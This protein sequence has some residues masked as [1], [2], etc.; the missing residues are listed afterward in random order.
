MPKSSVRPKPEAPGGQT[1]RPRLALPWLVPLAVTE[2]VFVGVYWFFANTRGCGSD[3]F[4]P[5]GYAHGGQ[6]K[7]VATGVVLAASVWVGAGVALYKFP[8]WRR[9][10]FGLG[11]AFYAVGLGLLWAITPL[12]WGAGVCPGVAVSHVSGQVGRLL[13]GHTDTIESVAFSPNRRL[14]ASSS[15]D[16]TIRLWDV[17]SQRELGRPLW[18][19]R[20][21][22]HTIAFSPDG[23]EL[24]SGACDGTVRLWDARTHRQLGPALL[25]G[26]DRACVNGVAFSPDGRLLVSGSDFGDGRVRLW[27]VRR[28]TQLGSALGHPGNGFND[29]AFS[30]DG[31]TVVA[32]VD[33]RGFG[34]VVLWDVRSKRQLGQPGRVGLPVQT[35]AFSPSGRLIAS[36]DADGGVRLWNVR[37]RR[38]G[39]LYRDP[40]DT[41]ESITFSRDGHTLAACFEFGGLR[42]WDVRSHRQIFNARQVEAATVSSNRD[43]RMLAIGDSDGTIRLLRSPY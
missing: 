43:G 32:G 26:R 34:A 37:G 20:G 4:G 21:A 28:H 35:V 36:G 7:S 24:A 23:R 29:V 19:Y 13:E 9:G 8:G 5:I 12:V 17:R 22:I 27:D 18:H 10:V 30:P 2:F 1:A 25:A 16:G 40:L 38:R 14:L 31:R 6:P 11:S 33:A 41:P 15:D 39:T 42:V 3:Q